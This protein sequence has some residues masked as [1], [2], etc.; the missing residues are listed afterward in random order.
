MPMSSSTDRNL[1]KLAL[2]EK[3]TQTCVYKCMYTCIYLCMKYLTHNPMTF[4][5]HYCLADFI[6][7]NW[8]KN[9]RRRRRRRG[10]NISEIIYFPILT[11]KNCQPCAWN[12]PYFDY[13]GLAMYSWCP[14]IWNSSSDKLESRA[15]RIGEV[16]RA[17]RHPELVCP[18]SRNTA[19][20]APPWHAY[21]IDLQLIS[22]ASMFR[23]FP[24]QFDRE[25]VLGKGKGP[26]LNPV[27]WTHQRPPA[28]PRGWKSR[29]KARCQFLTKNS[30]T[31]LFL[32]DDLPRGNKTGHAQ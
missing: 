5:F 20:M 28:T 1:S 30:K 27:L 24:E 26:V 18:S 11:N 9:K 22:R 29:R 4:P 15:R 3:A 31:C 7:W 2:G 13:G 8:L 16:S 10:R 12:C 6:S 32:A 17:Y 19:W 23:L 21:S 25:T 14:A